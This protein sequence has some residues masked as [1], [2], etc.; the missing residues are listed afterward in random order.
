MENLV[1]ILSSLKGFFPILKIIALI[2]GIFLFFD[3][4]INFTKKRLLKKIKAKKLRSNV[5]IFSR[6]SKYVV[7]LI[8]VIVGIFSYAGSWTG[9]GLGIGLFSAALGWALQKPITGIAAWIMVVFKRPFI[10]GDRVIIG[11]VRGDVEDIS[12]THIYLREIGGIVAGEEN[13]GRIIMIPNSLLFEKNIIN[14]TSKNEYVLDQVVVLVT[15]ESDIKEAAKISLKS[16]KKHAKEAIEKISKEPYVRTFFDPNGIKVSVR[17]FSPA[18]NLQEVS[19]KITQE[20]HGQISKNK[21]VRIAYPHAE[22]I[23]NK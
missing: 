1:N 13:S 19:S 22:V 4:V 20:I 15:Y 6:A 5:E 14:Y 12:L 16:A 11:D 3:F 8:L 9:L 7:F 21:K 18:K 17:Y 23:L 2:A 10:L